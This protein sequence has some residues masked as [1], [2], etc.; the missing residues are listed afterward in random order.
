LINA[1]L[2]GRERP[3]RPMV[4]IM[5]DKPIAISVS[6]NVSVLEK[7]LERAYEAVARGADNGL[8]AAAT[9]TLQIKRRRIGN[10]YARVIPARPGG[11]FKWERSRAWIEN[12][13]IEKTGDLEYTVRTTPGTPAANPITNYPEGYEERLGVLPRSRDGVMRQNAAAADTARFVAPQLTPLIDD[14][15]RKALRVAGLD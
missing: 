8:Q 1:P 15:I 2:W 12:Q 9:H 13:E 14:E 10:T 11:G 6:I 3:W 5:A 7:D 4:S